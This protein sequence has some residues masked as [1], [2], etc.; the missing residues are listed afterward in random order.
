MTDKP[1]RLMAGWILLPIT[2]LWGPGCVALFVWF[3]SMPSPPPVLI[4]AV[5]AAFV[6]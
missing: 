6:A 4:F 5:I 2:L 1:L 3:V